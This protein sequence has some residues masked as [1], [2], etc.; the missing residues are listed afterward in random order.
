MIT[1]LAYLGF[2]YNVFYIKLLLMPLAILG[3]CLSYFPDKTILYLDDKYFNFDKYAT[4]FNYSIFRILAPVTFLIAT[5]LVL[6]DLIPLYI[7]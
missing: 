3:I 7:K 5:I 6:I 2:A 4:K 1:S